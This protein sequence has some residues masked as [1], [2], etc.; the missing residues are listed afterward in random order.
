MKY[1]LLVIGLLFLIPACAAESNTES[2]VDT[3][4][5][6]NTAPTAATTTQAVATATQAA[7]TTTQVTATATPT[8]T[9]TDASVMPNTLQALSLIHI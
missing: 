9:A 4:N 2:L 1:L 7:A 5:E 3:F 6:N 8:T